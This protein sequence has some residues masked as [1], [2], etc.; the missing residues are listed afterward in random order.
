MIDCVI[1]AISF[2]IGYALGLLSI[3]LFNYLRHRH[4]TNKLE[5]EFID[6]FKN[7]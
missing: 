1:F 4:K 5:K 7:S 2:A 3:L 6:F